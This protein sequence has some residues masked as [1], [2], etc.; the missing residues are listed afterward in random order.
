M[1]MTDADRAAKLE[2]A[3]VHAI[4]MEK[5]SLTRVK[6]AA[7]IAQKWQ[8]ARKRIEKKI[9]ADHLRTIVNRL[10]LGVSSTDSK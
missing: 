9:G 3:L 5:R 2:R 1:A 8:R 4:E 7:T 6:R 10:S